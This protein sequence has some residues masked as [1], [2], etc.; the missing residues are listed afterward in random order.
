MDILLP[1][2]LVS[3]LVITIVSSMGGVGGAFVIIPL[4]LLLGYDLAFASTYG[5][6][7]NVVNTIFASVQHR[8]AKAIDYNAALPIILVSL[9]GAPLGTFIEKNV[10]EDILKLLF[11]VFL[12]LVGLNILNG[13]I[14]RSEFAGKEQNV[15]ERSSYLYK[16]WIS[17]II[18]VFA[19]IISG[20]FGLGG[21]VIILPILL[22]LGLDTKKAAGSTAFIVAFVSLA[23]LIS[24]LA[25]T[26]I[27]WDYTLLLGSI[28][29]SAMGAIIGSK[30]MHTKMNS[31]NIR[32]LIGIITIFVGLQLIL[33]VA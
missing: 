26:P 5:L 7:L 15:L 27:N 22:Y 33:S 32:L 12:I 9:I 4:F 8:K 6:L 28:I 17:I 11:A 31:Q 2:I 25:L 10:E 29:M 23:G 19:G 1:I 18:G 3:I 20:L 13:A 14:N 21:G 16:I 30:T 24:K